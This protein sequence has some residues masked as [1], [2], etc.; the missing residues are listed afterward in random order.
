MF[1]CLC[2]SCWPLSSEDSRVGREAATFTGTQREGG[3]KGGREGGGHL[4]PSSQQKR[5]WGA[6][7]A[8]AHIPLTWEKSKERRKKAETK[9]GRLREAG[10]HPHFSRV[11]RGRETGS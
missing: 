10:I 3:R 1:F 11:E 8:K 6:M 4:L 9:G 2:K 5:V 7:S